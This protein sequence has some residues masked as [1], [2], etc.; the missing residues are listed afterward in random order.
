MRVLALEIG[1]ESTIE[2]IDPMTGEASDWLELPASAD[3][4][5]HGV[6]RRGIDVT[7]LDTVAGDGIH[8]P[9][10]D[11]H[12]RLDGRTPG[13]LSK[14]AHLMEKISFFYEIKKQDILK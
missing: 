8:R 7:N 1:R 3:D 6:R 11:A 13:G 14:R 2:I 9:L 10:L 5:G 12:Q 4:P